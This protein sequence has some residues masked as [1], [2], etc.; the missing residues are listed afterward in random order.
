MNGATQE[1]GTGSIGSYGAPPP[2]SGG[3]PAAQSKVSGPAI[4]LMI[5]AGVGIFFNLIGILLNLL[6]IGLGGA[7]GQQQDA[8]AQMLG[9]TISIVFGIVGILVGAVVFF[10][11]MKMKNLE[12]YGFAMTATILAMIPCISP[13][14]VLGLPIGIWALVALLDQNV[15][16]SFR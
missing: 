6:G 7:F 10:G 2:P 1:G 11:A 14:C 9:G 8:V 5:T 15:K 4:G 16:A 13:C 3:F 12:S